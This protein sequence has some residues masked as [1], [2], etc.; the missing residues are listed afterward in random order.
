MNRGIDMTFSTWVLCAG[1]ALAAVLPAF[2]ARNIARD[3][4]D[5]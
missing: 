3:L 5:R 4:A 1:F 2:A